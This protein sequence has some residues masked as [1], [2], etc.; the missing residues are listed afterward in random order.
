MP[1]H[2]AVRAAGGEHVEGNSSGRRPLFRP[3]AYPRPFGLPLGL[4]QDL[5]VDDGR[6][7]NASACFLGSSSAAR[8]AAYLFLQPGDIPKSAPHRCFMSVI[9]PLNLLSVQGAAREEG[10]MGCLLNLLVLRMTG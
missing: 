9:C 1:R 10:I 3:V 4:R 8:T 6:S 5:D 2:C 7:L